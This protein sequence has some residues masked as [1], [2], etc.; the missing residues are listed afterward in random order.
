MSKGFQPPPPSREVPLPIGIPTVGAFG[1][2]THPA[3]SV[4][5]P[6]GDLIRA[7]RKRLEIRQWKPATLP[8]NNLVIVQNQHRLSSTGLCEDPAGIIVALVDVVTVREW[9]KE[10]LAAACAETWEDGWLAWELQNVRPL[11]RRGMVPARLRIY[12]IDLPDA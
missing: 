6:A 8:L 7:G 11:D 5:A 1:K 3:L 10:D 9:R 4:V 12:E 2:R